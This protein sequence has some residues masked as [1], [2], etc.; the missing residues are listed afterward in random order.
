MLSRHAFSV[1]YIFL[2]CKRFNNPTYYGK[3]YD[4]SRHGVS[5]ITSGLMGQSP[6]HFH[7]ISINVPNDIFFKV[8]MMD[9]HNF[10]TYKNSL[11]DFVYL[12]V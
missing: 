7:M 5:L 2:L 9:A 3:T 12:L 8:S 1:P 4:T 10:L 6:S 11:E